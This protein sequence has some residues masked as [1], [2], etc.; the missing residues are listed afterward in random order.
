M[1]TL[2]IIYTVKCRSSLA[3]GSFQSRGEVFAMDMEETAYT[4]T[5][6]PTVSI[7]Y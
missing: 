7:C 2:L 1:L 3:K 4:I 6:Q 5:N